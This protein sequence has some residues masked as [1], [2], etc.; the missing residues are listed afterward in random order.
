MQRCG[1]SSAMAARACEMRERARAR[2]CD[3]RAQGCVRALLRGKRGRGRA[4]AESWW[5]PPLCARLG[6]ADGCCGG[7]A[8]NWHAGPGGRG[9][10]G[11]GRGG[12]SSGRGRA[13]R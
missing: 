5:S 7:G 8:S 1:P 4:D 9:R 3:M 13:C 6:R 11:V 10:E 2:G 12:C